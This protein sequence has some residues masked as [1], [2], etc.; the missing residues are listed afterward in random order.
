MARLVST[1]PKFSGHAPPPLLTA[2]GSVLLPPFNGTPGP[3]AGRCFGRATP[4]PV[5]CLVC[6]SVLGAGMPTRGAMCVSGARG[7]APAPEPVAYLVAVPL[8]MASP[9]PV[10]GVPTR[11]P[12]AVL[13]PCAYPWAMCVSVP[14]CHQIERPARGCAVAPLVPVADGRCRGQGPYLVAVLV[15]AGLPVGLYACWVPVGVR[16]PPS[17]WPAWWVCHVRV[18]C[19][20][21]TKSNTRPVAV[22]WL[23]L[24]PVGR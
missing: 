17:Q 11:G 20:S 6:V 7:H 10:A 5:A 22:L 14:E 8:L 9:E 13:V 24:V 12:V 4:E 3:W 15:L 19:Q 16:P 2:W 23:A 1:W 21:A 18:G